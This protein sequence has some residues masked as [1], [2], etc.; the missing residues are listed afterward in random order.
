[1][2]LL[3]GGVLRVVANGGVFSGFNNALTTMNAPVSIGFYDNSGGNTFY[4]G[5]LAGNNPAAA[6]YDYYAGA[7]TMQVGALNLNTTFAGQFQTSVNLVKTGTGTLTLTGNSTHT[8]TTTVSSGALQVNGSFSSSPVTVA[9]GATLSGGGIL[10]GGVTIQTGGTISPG[11]GGGGTGTLSVSNNLT[12]NTANLNFDLSGSPTGA[13]DKIVIQNSALTMSGLQTYNFNLVNDALGAGTYALIG[14]ASVNTANGVSFASNLPANT[15]QNFSLQTPS[16][17]VQLV[18]TGNAGSLVWQGTNGGNW[19]LS[20]TVN[21]LNGSAADKFYNLDIV[22]FDDTSTNGNVSIIGMVQP[23]AV[24]VT[25]NLLDYAIGNGVLGGITSLTKSGAGML[26]LNSSNSFTGGTLVN[27][28][29]LQLVNN[30]YAGGF[31]PITLNGGTLFLN[32]I[33]TGTAVSSTGTNTLQTYGQPY[34]GFSLQGSGVLNLNIGGGGVFSPGGDWSGFSGTIN[35][36]T[37]NGL[38]EGAATFGSSNAVWNFGGAGGIYNKS[39]GATICLGALFGGAGAGLSGATTATASLTTYVVGG[40]NTNSIFGG[41]ISDGGAAGTALTF[42]GPGSL[43]LTGNNT[44]SGGTTVNGG[45]LIVNNTAGSGTG[46]GPVSIGSGAELGGNGTIGGQVSFAAGA[47]LAPGSNGSGTLAIANDLGLNNASI[48]QFQ[49]GTISD[50]VSVTGD[51]TLGGTLNISNAGG[52]GPGTYTLFNYGGALSVG[53]LAI[54]SAPAGYNYAI[55]TSVQGRVTLIVTQPQFGNILATPAGLVMSGSGG[56]DQR[57][58]LSAGFSQPR[59]A[60]EHLD[61]D[62]HKSV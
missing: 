39:G 23:A 60:V 53:A 34:A 16:S 59:R 24:L 26:T 3:G 33:G 43:T 42:A 44:F 48:L 54:G 4:F 27:G 28:G 21:W 41:V 37:G 18:V 7:P 45:A 56:A 10:G 32:G 46:S 2:N 8:G 40:V 35:F 49:L 9:S 1:M 55:D 52:F 6:F 62:C 25:N 36:T 61:A 51:L 20:S 5:A 13:N 15:R 11:S 47:T 58:F 57:Q 50:Q 30:Y 38:R 29:T 22:R 12:L 31:G 19:D 14:G 17:G